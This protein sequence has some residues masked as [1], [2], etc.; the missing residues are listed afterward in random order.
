MQVQTQF[1][2]SQG[3]V[4]IVLQAGPS[5]TNF[6][7]SWS[8][9]S[10]LFERKKVNAID[11]F[12][13]AIYAGRTYQID[14]LQATAEKYFRFPNDRVPFPF[15]VDPNTVVVFRTSGTADAAEDQSVIVQWSQAQ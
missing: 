9:L 4:D 13:E 8:L 2:S 10:I 6:S 1:L 5:T 15:Y 11:I 12:V 14:R 3:A 7:S